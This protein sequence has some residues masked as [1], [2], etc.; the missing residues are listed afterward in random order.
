[1]TTLLDAVEGR[2]S[3]TVDDVDQLVALLGYRMRDKTRTALKL[4]LSAIATA[5]WYE[6][7]S[8]V[9]KKNGEWF[10]IPSADIALIRALLIE[11]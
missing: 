9:F 4:K 1:M 10:C 6:K 2:I 5:R 3:L 7:Y 11:G 8:Q